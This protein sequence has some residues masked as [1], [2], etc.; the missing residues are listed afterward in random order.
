MYLGLS[1]FFG[2]CV[3][4]GYV[5][6]CLGMN[7]CVSLDIFGALDICVI[8]KEHGCFL[9]GCKM[10]ACMCGCAVHDVCAREVS[11]HV[12]PSQREYGGGPM[13]MH[14]CGGV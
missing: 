7:L 13:H 3:V 2:I 5:C 10:H 12:R 11:T 4:F 8:R 9:C 6:V 1:L 14:V